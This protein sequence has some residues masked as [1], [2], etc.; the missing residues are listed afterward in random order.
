M[1][2]HKVFLSRNVLKYVAAITMIID[3]F[4]LSFLVKDT[5]CYTIMR[6]WIGRIAF[7]LFSFLFVEGFF[8]TKHP[9]KH[10]R[11]LCIFALIS[12]LFFDMAFSHVWFDWSHQN[13]MFTWLLGF[14]ML[15][16]LQYLRK[17]K[18][19][20]G[21]DNVLFA[22][23][24]CCIV[25]VFCCIAYWL[26]VAYSFVGILSIAVGY[27]LML[28]QKNL[29]YV[30]IISAISVIITVRYMTPGVFL[31]IPFVYF[32]DRN[33]RCAHNNLLKYGFY[34]FYPAHL[35]VF[36]LIRIFM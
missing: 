17:S 28:Y 24:N 22:F 12:E 26:C 25:F 29:D 1:V 23:S 33:K 34:G 16:L 18:T 9:W 6:M 14:L 35:F 7:P 4:A 32:Y 31:S 8:R 36:S 2:N 5:I 3:H 10:I 15:M 30:F 11:D 13:V 20:L 27:F 19:D 21:L